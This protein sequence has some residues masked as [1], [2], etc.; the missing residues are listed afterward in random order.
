[1]KKLLVTL[2]DENFIKQAKQLFSSVYYNAGWDGDYMLLAHRIPEDELKWFRKKGIIV[3]KCEPIYNQNIGPLPPSTLSKFYLFTPEFKKWKKILYLDSDIIV[4][5]PLDSLLATSQMSAITDSPRKL[6]Y[7]LKKNTKLYAQIS[8]K[9]DL[10]SN[11]F[12]TGV[13]AFDTKIIQ[14]NTFSK[15]TSLFTKYHEIGRFGEGIFLNLLF[16]KSWEEMPRIFNI[17]VYKHTG[18]FLFTRMRDGIL[19][20]I[21][22]KNHGIKQIHIMLSGS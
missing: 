7:Q 19:H 15:L 1:M 21:G 8:K 18:C 2:A 6:S 10:E 22:S 20:F 14:K 5:T 11:A 3:K 16:Y 12:N 13:M 4:K 17:D 9:Y